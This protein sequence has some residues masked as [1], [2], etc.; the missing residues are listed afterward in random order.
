MGSFYNV[1]EQKIRPGVYRRYENVGES[2]TPGA[3]YGVFAMAIH[4][5]IGPLATV[6]TYGRDDIDEFKKTY[7]T[8]GTADAVLKLFEG[9][10][11]KVFVYRLGTGGAKATV[12]LKVERVQALLLSQL[13]QKR[14]K[15]FP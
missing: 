8:S 4:S 3:I 11:T 15:I 14:P 5:D 10:A 12:T 7:G 1:G 9:G 2:S 6:S 13:R